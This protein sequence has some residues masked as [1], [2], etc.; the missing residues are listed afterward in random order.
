MTDSSG[1]RL[2]QLSL[3]C[4]V[5]A[6]RSGLVYGRPPE[7]EFIKPEASANF[8]AFSAKCSALRQEPGNKLKTNSDAHLA[9]LLHESLRHIDR[10]TL[11]DP[12]V[13]QW[14]TLAL[15]PEYVAW[16]WFDGFSLGNLNEREAEGE[17]E[18]EH[19]IKD[20]AIVH[21]LGGG[22]LEGVSRNALAR[23]FWG[24]EAAW[25]QGTG[26]DRYMDVD[27]VFK[28]ADLFSGVFERLVCLRPDAAIKVMRDIKG[29]SEESRRSIMVNLNLVLS[30]TCLESLDMN[31]YSE[32]VSELISI[33]KSG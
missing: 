24:A 5:P 18:G 33:E 11:T 9:R 12:L 23:L 22:S 20:S 17:A 4:T 15:F 19:V 2:K 14:M 6:A 7:S 30:T 3:S 29:R 25:V 21:F 1:V 16:R 27:T 32:L 13:W 28:F 8:D 31:T 10:R 26:K